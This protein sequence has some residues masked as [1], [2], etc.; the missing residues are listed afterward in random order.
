MEVRFS[1]KDFLFKI[2]ER[3]KMI[4]RQSNLTRENMA[5]RL[6]KSMPAYVKN[7]MGTTMPGPETLYCLSQDFNISLDWFLRERGPMFYKEQHPMQADEMTIKKGL[8]YLE[9]EKTIPELETFLSAM[10]ADPM[11]RHEM[12]L[13][14]YKHQQ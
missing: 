2:A 13:F 12:L 7:E 3:L 9:F 4:R 6:G 8:K 10:A 5:R 1:R 14:F 11:L